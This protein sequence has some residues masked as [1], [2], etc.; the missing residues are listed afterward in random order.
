MHAD[1]RISEDK[2]R[3][4]GNSHGQRSK[5]RDGDEDVQQD[6]HADLRSPAYRI[7]GHLRADITENCARKPVGRRISF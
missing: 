1:R 6:R 4:A 3:P 7:Y 5:C 2:I